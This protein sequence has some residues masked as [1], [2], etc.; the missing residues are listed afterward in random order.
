MT[1]LTAHRPART[2]LAVV[3]SIVVVAIGPAGCSTPATEDDSPRIGHRVA[4]L[5]P[6][7]P[8]PIATAPTPVLPA[9]V[10]D[11]EG[12][13]VTVEDVSRIVAVDRHGT[14]TQ[15]VY[16]L[17]L[18]DN[19]VGRDIAA[20][21]PAVEDVPVVNPGGQSLNAE[22]ILDL[23]PT[24]VLTDT[25]IGPRGVQDQL[26]AAGVPVLF[27]DPTRSLDTVD[28]QIRATAAVLGLP[29]EGTALADRTQSEIAA[30]R[31][32]APEGA[33]PL[34][35]A[36]VYSR[37][38]AITMLGGPG[39]GA[40]SLIDALGA[41]DAGTRAG[42]TAEFTAITSEAMIAAS[43]DA[44]LMMTH[45]LESIGGVDGLEQVPGI[46]QTPAGR[47]ESV[48]D[49][50]DGLLLGFGPNTGRVL[51]ALADAFYPDTGS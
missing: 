51:A 17:G 24:V 32:R 1:A 27:M 46:A 45:G 4:T 43:P 26:R 38:P 39:S 12:T 36:F 44:F 33:D 41:V 19:L 22:A 6:A 28:D 47:T 50:E 14:L 40:D 20:K 2:L 48:V 25:T 31:T 42:L 29:D 11:A 10:T 18:G 3:A 16:A 13:E 7:D 37:G 30:A 21:F 9:T 34:S 35:I 49:M 8:E 23:R 5:D 15:T